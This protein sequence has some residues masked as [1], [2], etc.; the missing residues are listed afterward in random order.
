ML[1]Q[2]T[3]WG[4]EAR[5]GEGHGGCYDNF[6]AVF[7]R[8][9]GHEVYSFHFF[10]LNFLSRGPVL[11]IRF[12]LGVLSRGR[13]GQVELIAEYLRHKQFHQVSIISHTSCAHVML[14][15]HRLF[16]CCR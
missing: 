15:S 4:S 14:D 8:Y 16:L 5:E 9:V 3:G 13:I 2:H 6:V 11:L 12:E 1:L 10:V 7:N